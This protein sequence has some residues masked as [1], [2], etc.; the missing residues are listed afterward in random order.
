MHHIL[1]YCTSTATNHRS[2]DTDNRCLLIE[3][4]TVKLYLQT[5]H[6]FKNMHFVTTITTFIIHIIF[7]KVMAVLIKK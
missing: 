6:S 7:S 3:P 2:S 1:V 4:V 5:V